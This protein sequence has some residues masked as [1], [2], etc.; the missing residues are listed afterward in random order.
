MRERGNN[1]RERSRPFC[2]QITATTVTGFRYLRT[3]KS[4]EGGAKIHIITV[5][6]KKLQ[7]GNNVNNATQQ[8][9]HYKHATAPIGTTTG[10]AATTAATAFSWVHSMGVSLLL[11]TKT[12][13]LSLFCCWTQQCVCTVHE[14]SPYLLLVTEAG[15]CTQNAHT[16]LERE[17]QYWQI[18]LFGDTHRKCAELERRVSRTLAVSSCQ[19][20]TSK[21]FA[22]AY[23]KTLL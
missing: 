13:S 7:I 23:L 14:H 1:Y 20:T 16:E 19:F 17:P 9:L 10:A 15:G 2:P 11:M 8:K 5:A 22:I 21:C 6:T 12:S 18:A 4:N 3:L